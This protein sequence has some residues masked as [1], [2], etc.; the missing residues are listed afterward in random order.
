MAAGGLA[1]LSFW[2][3]SARANVRFSLLLT[4][5]RK[6]PSELLYPQRIIRA[7]P[8]ECSLLYLR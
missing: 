1:K 4:W 8:N 7:K 3:D 5:T 6:F 2:R